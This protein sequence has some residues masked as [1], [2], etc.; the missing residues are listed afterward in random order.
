MTLDAT[1]HNSL[2]GH[3][4]NEKTASEKQAEGSITLA[5]E[6]SEPATI[7]SEN[8]INEID[9]VGEQAAQNFRTT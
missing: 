5:K 6:G 3:Q 9:L 7:R 4:F 8:Q 2:S 1:C